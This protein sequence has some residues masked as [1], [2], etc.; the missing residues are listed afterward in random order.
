MKLF[1]RIFSAEI[2]KWRK[3]KIYQLILLSPII[4]MASA[5]SGEFDM[6]DNRWLNTYVAMIFT[7]GTLFLP[8][9]TGVFAG[10]LCRYEHLDGG[11]KQMLTLPIHRSHLYFVKFTTIMLLIAI[12]QLLLLPGL[13]LAGT[14]KGITDPIP[15]ELLLR[16]ITGGWIATFPLVAL[17]LWVSSAWKSFAAPMAINVIFTIPSIL[18]VNSETY[19]PIYPWAQPFLAMLPFSEQ[20]GIFFFS[21]QTLVL[22]IFGSF[23]LFYIGGLRMFTR[24]IY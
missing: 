17:Q 18:A 11:W 7:H 24:R 2:L 5:V 23:L 13:F 10:Y 8:M 6:S 12:M 21:V 4:S 1:M 14:I 15:Y 20:G 9:V 19:G 3:T 22:V 16:G